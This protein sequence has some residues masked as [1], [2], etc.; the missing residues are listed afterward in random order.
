MRYPNQM[1]L[2]KLGLDMQAA[3]DIQNRIM[4]A[5]YAANTIRN[6]RSSWGSFKSW[7]RDAGEQN[8]LPASPQTCIDHA[9]WCIAEGLRLETVHLRLKAINHYHRE[10]H[11]D[12]PF[13]DSVR[14]FMRNARRALQEKPQGKAALSPPQLRKISEKL[15]KRS[16][17]VDVRDRCMIVLCFACGWRCSE[18][19]SLDLTD[20]RWVRAGIVMW[21]GKSK[22]DQE[23]K[24]RS[25]GIPHGRRLSTCPLQALDEWLE[26]RGKWQGPLFTQLNPYGGVTKHRLG[27]DGV[28]RA[29]KRGLATIGED[30]VPF[31][32][33]SLRAGM[34]T[35]SIEAGASETAIMQ[36]TGQVSYDNLRRYVRPARAFRFNPL[37]GVL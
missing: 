30:P 5:N 16:E 14:H 35:A 25:V 36:R 27:A 18:L 21:L 6:Y 28:R 1:P 37:K 17:P 2:F 7:C 9:S 11:L 20:V 34:I 4:K 32:A 26:L 15:R 3:Q 10:H 19:V 24:G 22:T 13:D 33:H 23:G 12:L 8:S 31:G 29:V